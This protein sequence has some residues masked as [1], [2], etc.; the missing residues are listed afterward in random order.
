MKSKG[1]RIRLSQSRRSGA[2]LFVRFIPH[3][4]IMTPFVLL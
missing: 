1:V 4:R 2:P 3:K